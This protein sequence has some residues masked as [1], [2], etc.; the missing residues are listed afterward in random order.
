MA[1]IDFIE[2]EEQAV[3]QAPQPIIAPPESFGYSAYIPRAPVAA[4]P[5]WQGEYR[6]EQSPEAVARAT[7]IGD[8]GQPSAVGG[9]V[10]ALRRGDAG[11]QQI[12]PTIMAKEAQDNLRYARE[13][14]GIGRVAPLDRNKNLGVATIPVTESSY[15]THRPEAERRADISKAKNI[16]DVWSGVV[17]EMGAERE[18]IPKSVAQQELGAAKSAGDKWSV[19]KKYPG[20][21][22]SS[23]VLESLPPA[24]AGA[25]IGAPAGPGGV[26]AGVGFASGS[27]EF[28]GEFLNSAAEAGY[29][30]TDEKQLSA[31]LDSPSYDEAVGKASIRAAI[32]GGVDALTGGTAGTFI[33]PAL[34]EGLKKVIAASGKEAALQVGGGVG[35]EFAAQTA[36]KG[37]KPY[38]WF[39][40][41]MEGVA[42]IATG[43][44][45]V[46]SNVRS[47]RQ[48]VMMPESLRQLAKEPSTTGV[49]SAIQERPA[50]ETVRGLPQQPVENAPLPGAKGGGEVS[51]GTIPPR[52]AQG[53]PRAA[54]ARAAEVPLKEVT[55][56]ARTPAGE[57][58]SLKMEA[59][60][61]Q[62]RFTQRKTVLEALRDCMG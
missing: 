1:E 17:S 39:D 32:V 52:D 56:K 47:A 24:V 5:F 29:D 45:E 60:E 7:D 15:L 42:E 30:P 44:A 6:G 38:D 53:A 9:A 26:A 58:I 62:R 48:P 40:I 20:Q 43:P 31:F 55:I 33:K 13:R 25:V 12:F 11:A 46:F 3:A 21:V 49:P 50:A 27:A 61:A 57:E 54:E 41:A 8:S 16:R 37:D 2:D 36:T 18:A 34:K 51:S 23:I 19:F 4:P 10:N 22:V 35:G 14:A 28:A 59:G